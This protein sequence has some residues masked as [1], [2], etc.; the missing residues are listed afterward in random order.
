[1]HFIRHIQNYCAVIKTEAY[2]KHCLMF[3]MAH[4][5]AR[6]NNAWVRFIQAILMSDRRHKK[7]SLLIEFRNSIFIKLYFETSEQIGFKLAFKINYLAVLT[8]FKLLFTL[9]TCN[10]H[11][12]YPLIYHLGSVMDPLQSLHRF[13]TPIFIVKSNLWSFLWNIKFRNLIFFQKRTLVKRLG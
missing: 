13:Q 9:Q 12:L 1:M 5:A 7:L 8:Y 3:K 10:G 6:K 11:G 2:S 4:F